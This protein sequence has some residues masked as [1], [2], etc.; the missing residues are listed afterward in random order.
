MATFTEILYLQTF[1]SGKIYNT[2]FVELP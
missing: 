2:L 1:M